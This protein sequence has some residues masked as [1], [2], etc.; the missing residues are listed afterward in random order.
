MFSQVKIVTGDGNAFLAFLLACS[1]LFYPPY[2]AFAWEVAQILQAQC[3]LH[4]TQITGGHGRRPSGF[5]PPTFRINTFP[6]R[7]VLASISTIRARSMGVSGSALGKRLS[8]RPR[9]SWDADSVLQFS[10]L[11]GF[12]GAGP[13]PR[14]VDFV[15]GYKGRVITGL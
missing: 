10:S 12:P 14:A 4:P 2:V 8:T 3:G 11:D 13:G 15:I 5:M 6:C 9:V 7:W 1:S